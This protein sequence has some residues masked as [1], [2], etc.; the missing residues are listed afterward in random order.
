MPERADALLTDGRESAGTEDT[1]K[2]YLLSLL[3]KIGLCPVAQRDEMTELATRAH[4]RAADAN[5]HVDLLL[6]EIEAQASEP[7]QSPELD[8]AAALRRDLPGGLS[9]PVVRFNQRLL[10]MRF[11]EGC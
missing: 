11:P 4:L 9:V 10:A 3:E 5:H 7:P 8:E 1:V 6:A 2:K